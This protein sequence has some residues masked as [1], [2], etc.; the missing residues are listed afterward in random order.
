MSCGERACA[1]VGAKAWTLEW[2]VRPTLYANSGLC[3]VL[4]DDEC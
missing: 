1:F 4:V 3:V 2:L